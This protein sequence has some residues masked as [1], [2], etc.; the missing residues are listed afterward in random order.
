MHNICFVPDGPIEWASSRYRSYWPA[1]YIDNSHVV[2]QNELVPAGYDAYIFGK[3]VPADV[4]E[5]VSKSGAMCV[6]DV[7]DPVWWFSKDYVERILKVV[8]AVVC[9]SAPLANDLRW[10]FKGWRGKVRVIDDRFDLEHFANIRPREEAEETRFIWYGG[11]QNRLSLLGYEGVFSR[12]Q[13][14]GI[15]Y[16]FTILDDGDESYWPHVATDF[17]KW[18][19]ATEVDIISQHDIAFLPDYPGP[20]GKLKSANKRHMAYLCGVA[21]TDGMTYSLLRSVIRECK[22]PIIANQSAV[23]NMDVKKSSAAYK[24]LVH[25]LLSL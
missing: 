15:K 14:D 2:G 24:R 6:W 25:D 20:W 16:S 23:E 3:R 10:A 7:C 22:T 4:I 18:E 12:L 8:D 11:Y 9:S 5:E 17:Q 13:S 19:L 1:K 21:R